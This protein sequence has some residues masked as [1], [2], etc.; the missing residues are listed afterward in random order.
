[1][2]NYNW[3]SYVNIDRIIISVS[4]IKYTLSAEIW[5]KIENDLLDSYYYY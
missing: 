1:M 3:I 4:E 2:S 5:E